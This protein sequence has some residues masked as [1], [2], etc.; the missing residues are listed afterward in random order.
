MSIQDALIIYPTADANSFVSLADADGIL[1]YHVQAPLWMEL[2]DDNKKRRLIQAYWRINSL[3]GF[4]APVAPD[5]IPGCLDTAQALIAIQTLINEEEIEF[6]RVK[7][8]KV[9]PMTTTYNTDSVIDSDI[10]T[11]ASNCLKDYGVHISNTSV[12]SSMRKT[13]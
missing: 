10:P 1:D 4:L 12:L 9:G 8:E 6:N 5:P 13:R 3:D 7:Q 11:S 2:T